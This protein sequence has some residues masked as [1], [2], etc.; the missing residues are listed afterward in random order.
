MP[1]DVKL[2][3]SLARDQREDGILQK[4]EMSFTKN[5]VFAKEESV[6]YK[7]WRFCKRHTGE[8]MT[9]DVLAD[10]V[11]KS[12]NSSPSGS[13]AG[14]AFLLFVL[15]RYSSAAFGEAGRPELKKENIF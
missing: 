3:K 5:G 2:G 10:L 12:G 14:R 15:E 1:V 13:D 11:I 6:F 8:N 7:K 9:Y 4:R